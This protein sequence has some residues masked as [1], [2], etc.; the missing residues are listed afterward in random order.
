MSWGVWIKEKKIS[1]SVRNKDE[2]GALQSCRS[3]FKMKPHY[4]NRESREAK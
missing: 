2:K 1:D 4:E 3:E